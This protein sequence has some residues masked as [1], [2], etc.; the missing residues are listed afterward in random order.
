MEDTGYL[1]YDTLSPIIDIHTVDE[2]LMYLSLTKHYVDLTTMIWCMIHRHT[3]M[4]VVILRQKSKEGSIQ[5]MF[6]SSQK[7]VHSSLDTLLSTL[8]GHEDNYY[9]TTIDMGG[10]VLDEEMIKKLS[11]FVKRVKLQ[12]LTSPGGNFVVQ[13]HSLRSYY[14]AVIE[15]SKDVLTRVYFIFRE[16]YAQEDVET[17]CR[18]ITECKN[19]TSITLKEC[20]NIPY[21]YLLEVY[22]HIGRCGRTF[23][24]VIL[25]GIHPSA[26]ISDIIDLIHSHTISELRINGYYNDPH[27]YTWTEEILSAWA[28]SPQLKALF[29]HY[30]DDRDE[31]MCRKAMF[32]KG[33][34]WQ[35]PITREM[36]RE[37]LCK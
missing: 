17:V 27:S 23:E 9:L 3:K 25:D 20:R 34:E 24:Y 2:I 15:G 12:N 6:P 31:V 22:S 5:M 14:D 18:I 35:G 19:V 30:D 21:E 33:L 36:I 13:P 11:T 10:Y 4:L 16:D 29:I 37:H 8:E 7:H 32:D 28:S 26:P 1:N